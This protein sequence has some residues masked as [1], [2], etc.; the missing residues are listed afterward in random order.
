MAFGQRQVKKVS[1]KFDT[2][3]SEVF[4]MEGGDFVRADGF[5]WF[6]GLDCIFGFCWRDFFDLGE[7]VLLEAFGNLAGRFCTLVFYY[8]TVLFVESICH[9]FGRSKIFAFELDGL[10]IT[11]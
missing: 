6:G 3:L 4:E 10:I 5:R 1:K 7:V 2:F 9:V 8:R 11:I